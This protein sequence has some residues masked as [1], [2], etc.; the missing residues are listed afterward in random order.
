ML[1]EAAQRAREKRIAEEKE[2]EIEYLSED[3]YDALDDGEK[4]VY[5]GKVSRFKCCDKMDSC[6]C[7]GPF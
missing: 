3:E 6:E 5:D 2:I 7:Q 1:A 4:A